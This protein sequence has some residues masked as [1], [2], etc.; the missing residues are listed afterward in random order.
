MVKEYVSN[1]RLHVKDFSWSNFH[2]ID[3][4][5]VLQSFTQRNVIKIKHFKH[6]ILYNNL[7]LILSEF[8]IVKLK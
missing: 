3:A 7:F 5:S 8:N 2:F 1:N 6:Q 4:Y